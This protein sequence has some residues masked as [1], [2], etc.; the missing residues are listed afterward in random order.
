MVSV[1]TAVAPGAEVAQLLGSII[2]PG[3]VLIRPIDLI[4]FASDA[5]FYRLIPRAVVLSRGVEEI[6]ALFRFSHEHRIPLT[7]RAAGTSLSG[8]AIT[9]GILVEVARHWRDCE[10]ED[11]GQKVRVQPGIIGAHVNHALRAV[12][13]ARSVPIRPPLAPA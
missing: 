3:R 11:G 5:S 13:G 9:D 1:A 2:E 4:A 6:Q 12:P 7:F 10:V 8:Q